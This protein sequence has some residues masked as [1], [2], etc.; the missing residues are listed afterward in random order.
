MSRH[1]LLQPLPSPYQQR[2]AASCSAAGLQQLCPW[3]GLSRLK[4]AALS[5][6]FYVIPPRRKLTPLIPQIA[7]ARITGQTHS[8]DPDYWGDRAGEEQNY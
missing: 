4:S 3:T 7:H 6:T 2:T 8:E 5:S 1:E